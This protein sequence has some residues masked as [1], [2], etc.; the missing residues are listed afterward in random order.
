MRKTPSCAPPCWWGPQGTE[1]GS[2]GLH[3]AGRRGGQLL[4]GD[5]LYRDELEYKLA[6]D[7]DTLLE[8][9]A[10]IS[11]WCSLTALM[12]SPGV[13]LCSED[14][15]DESIGM[16]DAS[17]HLESIEEKELGIDPINAYNHYG[18]LSAICMEHDLMGDDF[19]KEYGEVVK[20]VKS[21]PGHTDLRSF[22]REELLGCLYSA[23][24]NK[25]GRVFAHYYYGEADSP[26]YPSDIDDYAPP[27]LRP[28]AVSLR[29]V[30]AGR[31]TCSFPLTRVLSGHR[32]R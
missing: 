26:Y 24:F 15:A 4:S 16:D 21:D 1:E 10:G 13:P 22:I 17:W 12:P 19:L 9:M 30:P 14:E 8:K 31:H 3:P 20:R 25:I 32:L 5:P 27:I 29:R 6:H 28:G 23:L 11:S 7:A 2:R 18:H